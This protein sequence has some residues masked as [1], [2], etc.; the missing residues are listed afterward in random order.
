MEI[1]S[2]DIVYAYRW[3]AETM[4]HLVS[5]VTDEQFTAQPIEAIN[6]PAWLFGHVSIYNGVIVALLKG[7]SFDNPWDAPC[8]KNSQPTAD[9]SAYPPKDEILARFASGV[10]AACEVIATATPDAW[11]KTLQH[12]TWGKQ[13]EAVAPAVTFLAT[14]HLA[15]HL[16]QLSGWR[17]A[18]ELPRI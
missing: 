4:Q 8:G 13:F 11:S 9:R 2:Q 14:S 12:S 1:A 17:R 6:H 7:E 5:D 15:L 18:M 3:A 16:G 10:E